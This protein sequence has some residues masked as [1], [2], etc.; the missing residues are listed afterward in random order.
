MK[1]IMLEIEDRYATDYNSFGQET[2]KQVSQEVTSLISKMIYDARVN[3][4]KK[5]VDDINSDPESINL[6]P[7]IILELLRIEEE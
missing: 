2:K 1:T 5:I 6:N 7:N 4:L 3:K